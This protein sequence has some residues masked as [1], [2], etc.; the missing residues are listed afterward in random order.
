[1]ENRLKQGVICRKVTVSK[2]KNTT[3]ATEKVCDYINVEGERGKRGR[4]RW[5]QKNS[6]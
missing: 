6:V 4:E 3:T 5:G 1:V 2:T